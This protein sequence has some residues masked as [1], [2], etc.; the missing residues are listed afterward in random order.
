MTGDAVTRPM[1]DEILNAEG[2]SDQQIL[3]QNM[4]RIRLMGDIRYYT[5]DV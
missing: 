5:R 1:I 2:R 4:H 3:A